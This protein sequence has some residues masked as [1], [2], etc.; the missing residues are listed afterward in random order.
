M[1]LI[2]IDFGHG[3]TTAS[4]INTADG[5]QKRLHILDGNTDEGS[6][7]ESAVCRDSKTGEWHFAKDFTDYSSPDFTL[8]FKAPMNEITPKNKEAFAAFV[9]LVYEHILANND[10][11]NHAEFCIYAACPSGWNNKDENQIQKYKDFLSDQL[12]IEWVIKESDAAYFKF[13]AE[14]DFDSSST[15]LV[16][17]IGSS[18]IDFTA[19][20]A[21]YESPLSVGIKH[22]ASNVERAICKYYNENDREFIEAKAKAKAPC[23]KY[24]K[25]WNAA[26]LH[27][28]KGQ[29]EDFYTKDL[30]TLILD[31]SNRSIDNALQERIFNAV[32]NTKLQLENEI[33]ISYASTLRGD[34]EMVKGKLGSISIVVLTG[35]ASRMPWLQHLVKDVFNDS[36]VLRDCEPSYVVSDGIAHYA[37]A[38]YKLKSE[39]ARTIEVFWSEHTDEKLASE[40]WQQFNNSLRDVQLPKIKAICD[41][42]DNGNLTYNAEDF[43][44]LLNDEDLYPEYNGRRCTA[45]FVPAMIKHNNEILS[46]A[47]DEISK[48]VNEKMNKQLQE[49]IIDKVEKVFRDS[50]HGIVPKINITPSVNINIRDLIIDNEWDINAIVNMTKIIFADWFNKGDIYKDRDLKQIRQK[51]TMVFYEAQEKANVNLPQNILN[52]A[53]TSLKESIYAELNV[54]NMLKKCIFSIY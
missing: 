44:G 50:L 15:V 13:K 32:T 54:E 26:V 20:G 25:N 36:R 30:N 40:I 46:V 22:G 51:F 11:L 1:Y 31:L 6:K 33:L 23:E 2:G 7:V 42:F 4:C 37:L 28:V 17:D 10:F 48:A 18:T 16:I 24:N 19:Y 12:P 34:L 5:K 14:K 29:K 49:E 38:R 43:R 45:A 53:V 41:N 52:E 3:E 39:I 21:N 8:Y 9:K 47:G 27:Y 35:G